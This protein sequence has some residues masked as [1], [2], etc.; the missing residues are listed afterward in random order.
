MKTFVKKEQLEIKNGGYLLFD[1]KPVNNNEFVEA[2]KEAEYII[3]FTKIA[4][5]KNFK[6]I[7]IDNIDDVKRE[8]HQKLNEKSV[9]FVEVPSIKEGKLHNS[10]KLEALDFIKNQNEV[11]KAQKINEFMQQFRILK[12]FEEVGLYFDDGLVQLNNIY[13]VDEILKS[14]NEYIDLF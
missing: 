9:K 8:V 1:G 14:V 2:Q 13:T 5:T 6:S 7:K 12:T 3:T 11:E 4:K 10:L